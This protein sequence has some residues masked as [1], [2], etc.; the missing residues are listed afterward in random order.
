MHALQGSNRQPTLLT[1][2][3]NPRMEHR[4]AVRMGIMI[5][6]LAHG[7][8]RYVLVYECAKTYC[9]PCTI[10][11][12]V[13]CHIKFRRFKIERCDFVAQKIWKGKATHHSLRRKIAGSGL[14]VALHYFLFNFYTCGKNKNKKKWVGSLCCCK[15]SIGKCPQGKLRARI[16]LMTF[17]L[18]MCNGRHS[19]PLPLLP[20]AKYLSIV[21]VLY[22]VV[23]RAPA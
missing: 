20:A 7:W 12:H 5:A 14:P 18:D 4:M 17:L 19:R 11:I 16:Q 2:S 21:H 8:L 15:K 22:S 13:F 9:A 10:F 23:I 3:I 1:Y 6:H